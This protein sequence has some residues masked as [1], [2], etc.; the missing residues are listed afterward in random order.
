MA[1]IE[2]EWLF[3]IAAQ[4][5]SIVE[6]GSFLGR[7]TFVLCSACQGK[8]YAV[9][10]FNDP[11]AGGIEKHFGLFMS[12]VGHF[13]NLVP[14]YTTSIEAASR[15]D[16]PDMVDMVLV[17][18]DHEEVAVKKDLEFWTPRTRKLICG[19][20]YGDPRLFGVRKAVNDFFGESNIILGPRSMWAYWIQ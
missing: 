16:I 4:I 2:L 3:G 11:E 8:V 19:H 12:N 6:L 5:G 15:T 14:V 20:D 7:S 9:D 13:Q 17:D 10:P 1:P 18:A